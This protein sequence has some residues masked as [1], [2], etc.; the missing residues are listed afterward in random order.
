MCQG[1]ADKLAGIW[2]LDPNTT[3][4]ATLRDSVLGRGRPFA[5]ETWTRVAALLDG[6]SRDWTGA[7]TVRLRG[8]ARPG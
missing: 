5:G 3:R 2:E 7:Y 1:A 8:D 6:Y 4:R